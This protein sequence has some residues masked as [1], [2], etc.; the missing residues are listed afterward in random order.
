MTIRTFIA[1]EIP[2]FAV[3]KIVNLRDTFFDSGDNIKWEPKNKYHLTLKFLGDTNKSIIKNISDSIEDI[4]AEYEPFNITFRN[5]GVFKREGV[6]K[7][8]W[9]GFDE[10]K[11]LIEFVNQ[12]DTRMEEFS[13]Q[14]EN[15]KFK[16]HL[17]ILRMRGNE[18]IQKINKLTSAGTDNFNFSANTIVFFKSEL[19]PSGSEY[20]SIKKFYL[21]KE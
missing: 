2:E 9:A 8:L 12:I 19:K 10:N 1:L 4:A 11:R 13:F 7:I 14:K 15:R 6:P 18:D 16:P 20:T 3:N 17:T 5:F 21:I